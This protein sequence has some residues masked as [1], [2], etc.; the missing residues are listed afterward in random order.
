MKCVK[1]GEAGGIK[2]KNLSDA[3]FYC[4][5]YIQDHLDQIPQL[6]ISKLALGASVS[7]STVN[8]TLKK[9]GYEGYKEF[10][11]TI[12]QTRNE[13]KKN[14]F[15]QEVNHAIQKNE[16]EITRTIN[17]LS[18]E[19]IETSIKLIDH[20]GH[21]IIFSAG[22]SFNV[23]REMMN[24]LQ[25][26]GK[27][28]ACHDDFDCMNYYAKHVNQDTLVIVISLSGET[29][30]I[31]TALKIVKNRHSKIIAL[32]ASSTSQI[33]SL[34]DVKISVY[35]STHKEINF[36]LDVASRIPLQVANRIL[37]DA[38]AIYKNLIPIRDQLT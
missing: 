19:D 6:S 27:D 22:P 14:G 10:K 4:W 31:V 7:L 18:V 38:F 17:Q 11:E 9:L 33:A 37:L 34:A 20:H 2:M 3:E 12:R 30:E 13:R 28:C 1:I 32:T 36:G 5:T 8:R 15:S 26:F 21:I 23:A 35:K 24:K 16:I 29:P 25:L